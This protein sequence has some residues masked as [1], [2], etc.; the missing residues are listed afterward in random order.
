MDSRLARSTP[1]EDSKMQLFH[2]TYQEITSINKLGRFGEFLFFAS[3]DC[4][5][6]DITYSIEIEEEQVVNCN[7]FFYRDDYQKL[8]SLVELIMD[9]ADCDEDQAQEYLS[10]RNHH[11]DAEIDW[12]IQKYTAKAAK[13]LGFRGVAVPDEHGVSYM[14][15]M[16]G[17]ENELVKI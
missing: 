15:D 12:D 11:G 4:H 13:I 9:V 1:K 2:T 7:S 16:L 8:N 3:S 17:F 14:I 10:Q 5:Y 6:G